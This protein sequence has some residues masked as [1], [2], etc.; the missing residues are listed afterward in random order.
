M[1]LMSIKELKLRLEHAKL[2]P[3]A[4]ETGLSYMV[5]SNI[6][7]G[8]TENPK[9]DT[10]ERITRHFMEYENELAAARQ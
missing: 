3:I 2:V 4:K 6:A 10:V 8:R 9:Y 1:Y 7:T 5:L